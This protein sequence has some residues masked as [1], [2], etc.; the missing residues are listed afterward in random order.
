MK[1]GEV[2]GVRGTGLRSKWD[3]LREEGGRVKKQEG[4]KGMC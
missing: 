1:Q 3:A 4:V 2:K